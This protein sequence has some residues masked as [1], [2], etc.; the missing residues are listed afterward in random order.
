MNTK[1]KYHGIKSL[2]EIYAKDHNTTIKLAEERVK[3]MV[4]LIEKG[5]ADPNYD[6]IQFIDSITLRKVIRQPK[7]GRNPRTLEE[8][9]IPK[10]MGIKTEIGKNFSNILKID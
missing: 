5:L 9:F 8:V 7:K 6:G 10:R 4:E 3:E 1:L 2:A